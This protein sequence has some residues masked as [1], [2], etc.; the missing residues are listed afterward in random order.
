[1]QCCAA[2]RAI[3]RKQQTP[4]LWMEGRGEGGGVWIVLLSEAS[5]FEDN[6]SSILSPIVVT[7]ACDQ[8]PTTPFPSEKK[9]T[10]FSWGEGGVLYTGFSCSDP[11][12]WPNEQFNYNLFK[13]H[14]S[15]ESLHVKTTSKV[16][17]TLS[18]LLKL[19]FT[20]SVDKWRVLAG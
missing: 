3:C 16:W 13:C 8:T 4:Q 20:L 14:N 10:V 2:V 18:T 1:M 11:D 5:P 19:V 15:N 7:V 9:K 6:V 12:L 17:M